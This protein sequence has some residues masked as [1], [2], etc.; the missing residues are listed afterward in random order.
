M[1]SILDI[2]ASAIGYMVIAIIISSG[3]E[4]IL[5]AVYNFLSNK[6]YYTWLWW[7]WMTCRMKMTPFSKCLRNGP[8]L[9]KIRAEVLLNCPNSFKKSWLNRIDQ[10]LDELRKE[11]ESHG[12]VP[13]F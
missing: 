10:L 3:G 1:K 6:F 9:V 13:T 12:E 8:R 5:K 7:L 4:I 2:A 11:I